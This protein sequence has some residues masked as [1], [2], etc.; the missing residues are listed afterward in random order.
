MYDPVCEAPVLQFLHLVFIVLA[1]VLALKLLQLCHLRVQTLTL[2]HLGD[3]LQ[4]FPL[5][6]PDVVFPGFSRVLLMFSA[7]L[8]SEELVC[9]FVSF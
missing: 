1:D 3:I 6:F 7:T 8:I 5:H 9:L 2:L 4:L